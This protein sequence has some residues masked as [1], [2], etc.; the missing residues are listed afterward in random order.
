[1]GY[2]SKGFFVVVMMMVSVLFVPSVSAEAE[3]QYYYHDRYYDWTLHTIPPSDGLIGAN[4]IE[5][6]ICGLDNAGNPGDD[7]DQTT[8]GKLLFHYNV[9]H[10][11]MGNKIKFKIENKLA[12][13]IQGA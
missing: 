10:L 6:Y 7:C 12:N 5:R 4:N 1:M 9:S 13:G 8:Q 2:S 11:Q 3:H